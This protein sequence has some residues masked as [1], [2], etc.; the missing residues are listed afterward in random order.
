MASNTNALADPAD[1]NFDDWFELYNPGT[2]TVDIAGYYL[3]DTLTS[4]FK[5]LIT[6]N[7][8]HTIAPH[9]FLLVWADN[10]TSENTS[11]GV[12]RAD[13]HVNFQLSKSG[14]AIGLFAADGTQIDA[15][16]FL[17]QTDNVSMGRFPDGGPSIYFMTN[18]T[19]RMP[20]FL[21]QSGNTA[22]VLDPIGNK[23][24]YY[25]QTLAFTA[26]ASDSDV[27]AQVLTFSLDP[28]PPAGASITGAGA[29]TFTPTAL[30]TNTITVR[31]TD[32]GSPPLSDF[33]T[34]TVQV[35]QT[36]NLTS[37]RNGNNLEFT[38]GTIAGRKYAVDFK[39][40]LNAAQWTPLGTNTASGSSLSFTNSTTA[41]TNGFFRIR[42][43]N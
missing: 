8:P 21:P 7:G 26:T 41:T 2:N 14:E 30:G 23:V 31:V 33:E 9:G 16:T 40:D 4:K 36:P 15:I 28:T 18:Y 12:P 19:P 1:G 11:G 6:T 5:Y 3:T 10:Q 43:V 25:G 27:P 20:N 39:S 32:S 17:A 42:T 24:L 38:L 13:L 35:L 29:F 34:I 37:L 22:P